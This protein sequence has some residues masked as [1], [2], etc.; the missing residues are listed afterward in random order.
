MSRLFLLIVSVF[1]L[2]GCGGGGRTGTPGTTPNPAEAPSAGPV[3]SSAAES[4]A[5]SIA[6]T[7]PL[8]V[9]V[10]PNSHMSENELKRFYHLS[11]GSEL[12][13]VSW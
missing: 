12:F 2:W 1:A 4:N 10:L 3:A 7:A 9:S 13:P 11:E 6:P 8:P 5:R